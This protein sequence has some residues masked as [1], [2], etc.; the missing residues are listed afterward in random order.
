MK[1]LTIFFV[2]LILGLF[3]ISSVSASTSKITKWGATVLETNDNFTEFRDELLKYPECHMSK[4][5][6]TYMNKTRVFEMLCHIYLNNTEKVLWEDAILSFYGY[7]SL[8][9]SSQPAIVY[10]NNSLIDLEGVQFSI[11]GN[12]SEGMT[13]MGMDNDLL[14]G[15]CNE[16]APP[17][18]L[19]FPNYNS[20]TWINIDN[21]A[22]KSM[23][24]Q[25]NGIKTNI[26]DRSIASNFF[27]ESNMTN[28]FFENSQPSGQFFTNGRGAVTYFDKI[29]TLISANNGYWRGGIHIE[30][31]ERVVLKHNTFCFVP[32][33]AT[34]S[35]ILTNGYL[36]CNG[37]LGFAFLGVMNLG[38]IDS[39][40]DS[41]TFSG[42]LAGWDVPIYNTIKNK[43]R[44][45]DGNEVYAD[46][47][48]VN[49]NGTIYSGSGT[50]F[51]E[52]VLVKKYSSV[53]GYQD[54]SSI[55]I[56][57]Q[58]DS[59]FPTTNYS[60]EVNEKQQG[61]ITMLKIPYDIMLK[62]GSAFG[63]NL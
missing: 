11:T 32:T 62:A 10:A 31:S 29:D 49:G 7:S 42:Y 16:K 56:T 58:N 26:A 22:F 44:N 46:Y 21:S 63:L 33:L 41:F 54:L 50:A 53:T 48:I 4:A 28:V 59:Y 61:Y 1:K 19:T 18:T 23:S 60:W 40:S 43:F 38:F 35:G 24:Y 5:N 3:L 34:V 15:S 45:T 25:K 8:M 30:N 27:C 14:I 39:I 51:D 2:F 9:N 52:T 57:I 12:A 17:V 13:I 20:D 47:S 36:E 55:K 37:D 6:T